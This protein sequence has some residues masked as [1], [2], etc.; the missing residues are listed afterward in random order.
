MKRAMVVLASILL[1]SLAG[2]FA[3]GPPPPAPELKKLDY[4][5]GSWTMDGDVKP[6]P[7]GPGGKH[8]GTA[9]YEWMSGNYFLVCHATFAGVMGEGTE[10]SYMGYDSAKGVYTYDAFNSMGTHE[11]AT[12]KLEGD[13]W[14]W[15]FVE[16][17]SG[18]T[19]KAHFSMK[20]LSPASYIYK[21]E[22]SPDG[23]NWTTVL[24]GKATKK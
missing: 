14:A 23:T 18:M 19:I 8:T 11:I 3:Q 4:F 20:M 15:S 9:K 17:I 12:G 24:E 5:T 21:F 7:A 10:T 6:G 1:T 16:D 22:M 13:T 2:A